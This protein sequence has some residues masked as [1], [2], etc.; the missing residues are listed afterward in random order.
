MPPRLTFSL[1]PQTRDPGSA[2]AEAEHYLELRLSLTGWAHAASLID[3][4]KKP[5]QVRCMPRRRTK[6]IANRARADRSINPHYG[7]SCHPTPTPPP[8]HSALNPC[9]EELKHRSRLL[10]L[11]LSQGSRVS[12]AAWQRIGDFV[13][14]GPVGQT[15]AEAWGK[16]RICTVSGKSGRGRSP[17]G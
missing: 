11:R 14:A 6:Q 4:V 17:C 2:Q 3:G 7:A 9:Y 5:G 10:E 13:E 16:M 8:D 12:L 1:A 15:G